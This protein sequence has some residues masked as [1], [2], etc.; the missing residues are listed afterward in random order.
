M[1]DVPEALPS[2]PDGRKTPSRWQTIWLF[3]RT[4]LEAVWR[5]WLCRGFLLTSALITLLELKGMQGEQKAASQM[6]EAVY[7][8]Y[9]LVWMHG[10]IFIAGAALMRESDCLNEAILCRGVTRGEYIAGKLTAR[11]L[12]VVMMVAG[13]LLPSSFWAIRQDKLV[14]TQDGFVTSAARNIKVEA[15]EPKKVFAEV[16][17]PIKEMKLQV[18]DAVR[19]GDVL[20][21][22][23]DRNIFDELE[24]ERRNEENARNEVVNA[25]RRIEEAKR[26]VI[27]AEDA[28]EQAERTMTNEMVSASRKVED[29]RRSVAQAEDAL[30]HAERGLINK[31]LLSQAEQADRQT[32]I[33]ARKRDIMNA[34]SLL[35]A[36]EQA[37]QVDRQADIRARKRDIV[38]SKSLLRIAEDA[39]LP[40]ERA[41]ENAQ[42]RVREARRRLGRVSVTAP[43]SG[44][45]TEVLANPAQYVNVG[46]QLAT[47]APL[48]EYL[49]R[50]PIYKYDEFKRLKTGLAAIVK[51]EATEYQGTIERLGA[52]TQPDRWGRDSN[53]AIVR[54]KGDGAL[55]LMGL[56]ADVKLIL[57]P[58]KERPSRVTA[59][60]NVLTGQT[61]GDAAARS[62]S[63]TTGWMFIGLGK[64]VG[65]ACMLVTL[66][67]AMLT[68]FRNSLT[69][70]L[71]VVGLW[72]ISNLL[73]DFVGL[74]DVSYMEMVGNMAKVLGGVAKPL[75]ELIVLAWLFG[76]AAAFA[77]LTS[78]L[79]ITRDPAK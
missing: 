44:Y 62:A 5:S 18:G 29:A 9:L 3:V 17:G 33:R 75:D 16:S 45:V 70:I 73:F 55:G 31:D 22:L 23:D 46:A 71:C 50:V 10:V 4:D 43:I 53:Y 60:L 36:A 79:F 26:S 8:T 66:T 74:R 47:I 20:A 21:T 61:A 49:V 42:A 54:F 64:V 27:H 13:V 48:D 1:P 35:R 58:P 28:L 56:P 24:N 2:L 68:L 12:A 63:V 67:L 40:A 41:V 6:L 14:R 65:S 57:P 52:M 11:C 72:H 76:L 77:A 30:D 69:A 38:N 32:D 78:W 37:E 7:A 51:I 19:A 59:M 39:T 34:E 25:G 15:W